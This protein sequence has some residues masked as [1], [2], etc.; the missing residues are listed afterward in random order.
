[1]DDGQSNF[2]A[3]GVFSMSCKISSAV[4][5]PCG[6]KLAA[7]FAICAHHKCGSRILGASRFV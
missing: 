4:A 1:M 2:T 3:L 6:V 5:L 7:S